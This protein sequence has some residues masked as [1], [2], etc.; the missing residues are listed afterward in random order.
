MIQP[1]DNIARYGLN[2]ERA[3]Y[4][5]RVLSCKLPFDYEEAKRKLANLRA[6]AAAIDEQV[7]R[8]NELVRELQDMDVTP[9]WTVDSFTLNGSVDPPW[10]VAH[11]P[12]VS[13]PL[14]RNGRRR[15][16]RLR[17]SMH[18]IASWWRFDSDRSASIA[19]A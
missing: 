9:A 10:V 6:L 8:F 14:S 12:S 5:R 2:P 19:R 16:L 13:K 15:H 17:G 3:E 11:A 18:G 1:D 4:Y 7:K